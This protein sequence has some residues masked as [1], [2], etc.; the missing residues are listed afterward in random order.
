MSRAKCGFLVIA[1]I[2]KLM[3]TSNAFGMF[4]K[5]LL[6]STVIVSQER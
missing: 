4:G 1:S 2:E 5:I 3:E 6:E